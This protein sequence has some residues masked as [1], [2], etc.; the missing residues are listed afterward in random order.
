M[1]ARPA[2]VTSYS[3]STLSPFFTVISYY[4]MTVTAVADLAL[5]LCKVVAVKVVSKRKGGRERERRAD[6]DK[7][8]IGPI[9]PRSRGH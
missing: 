8:E 3:Y 7:R 1:E 4:I 5:S 9:R 2:S 6:C